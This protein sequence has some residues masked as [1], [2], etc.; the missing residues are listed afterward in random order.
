MTGSIIAAEGF[1]RYGTVAANLSLRSSGPLSWTGVNCS[2]VGSGPFGSSVALMLQYGETGIIG[3]IQSVATL[4]MHQFMAIDTSSGVGQFKIAFLDTGTLQC[5]LI[6]DYTTLQVRLYSGAAVLLASSPSNAFPGG[7]SV[8]HLQAAL[9]IGSSTGAIQILI[10]GIQVLNVGS[11]DTQSTA[12]ATLNGFQYEVLLVGNNVWIQSLVLATDS[13]HGQ[14]KVFTAFPTAAGSN[15]AFTP[16]PT[17]NYSNVNSP[18][19]QTAQYN[20]SDTAS[21]IDTFPVTSVPSGNTILT[22]FASIYAEKDDS[23][24]R[25]IRTYNKSSSASQTGSTLG[26]TD[27]TYAFIGYDAFPTDPNTSSA[28]TVGGLNSAEWGYEEVA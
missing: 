19:P 9:T 3:S 17:P 15:S 8:F 10:N 22:V 24:T 1:G 23:G 11:L 7:E 5:Y 21:Q 6:F 16:N 20:S 28:W 27:G 18:T 13:L 25:T 12:N 4:Y 2:L 14:C 26:L